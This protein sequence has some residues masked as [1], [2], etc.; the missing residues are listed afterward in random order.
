MISLLKKAE[1]LPIK[2]LHLTIILLG[3]LLAIQIQYIQ[4]GSINPDSLLYFESARLFAKGEWQQ[5]IGVFGWPLYSVLIAFTHKITSLDIHTSAQIL[6]VIFFGITTSSFLKIIQLAGGNARVM[7]AGGLIL[8]SSHY[9]AGD[10][11]E[12]LMRDQGFWAFFLTSLVFFIQFYKTYSYKDAFFWQICAIIAT[13]FRIEGITYLI[14]L[15]V[16]LFFCQQHSIWLRT[17]NFL[18]CNY[19]S[20]ITAVCVLGATLIFEHVSMKSFG[21]LNEIFTISL[22][23]ELTQNLFEKSEIMSTQVLGKYLNEYAIEA[24]LLTF[25]YIMATKIISATGLVNTGL[26][27]LAVKSRKRLMD[28]ETFRVLSTTAII[29]TINMFLIITKVFVLSGRYVL[30]LSFVLMIFASFYLA[31]A[32]KYLQSLPKKDREIK[33]VVI[34]LL[35]FMFLSLVKNIL[36][37]QEGYNYR[38]DAVTWLKQNNPSNKA[39]FYDDSRVRYYAGEPFVSGGVDSWTMLSSAIEANTLYQYDFLVISYSAKHPEREK[40]IAEKLTQYREIKRFPPHAAKK[41]LAIYQ[42]SDTSN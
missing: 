32:F 30:A 3:M 13:L 33:W 36:P 8:F 14:A 18:K 26:A 28:D 2:K 11:L 12:M 6:S 24:I 17:R 35:V 34:A 21:R 42:K 9:L 31:D 22:Y 37:K 27:L 38:Q 40:F 7:L 19:L 1:N 16:V 39:V 25:I 29:A 20:T 23:G 41:S 10:V 4:H 15:P 5:A